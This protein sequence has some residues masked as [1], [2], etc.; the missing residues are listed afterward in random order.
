MN[1]P[2][3]LRVH[4]PR[5]WADIAGSTSAL[6]TKPEERALTG[7]PERRASPPP[8]GEGGHVWRPSASQGG[9]R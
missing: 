7:L 4:V 1:C 9:P 3:G 6:G 8:E 5:P 2:R